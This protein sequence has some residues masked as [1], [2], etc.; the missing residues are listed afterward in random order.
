MLKDNREDRER[1]ARE[2]VRK[3]L[4]NADW[5]FTREGNRQFYRSH[6]EVADVERLVELAREGDKDAL[7]I[8]RKHAAGARR[9]GMNAPRALHEFV[10]ECFVDGPPKAPSGPSPKDTGLRNTTI[11]LL[12]K[13]VHED[14]GFPVYPRAEHHGDPTAPPSACRL[15]AEELGLGETWVAEIWDDRKAMIARSRGPG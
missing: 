14:H 15:V 4:K 9:A 5:L 3:A 11:A 13:M 12:V 8:L 10:W 7:E 2:S 6:M 1:L